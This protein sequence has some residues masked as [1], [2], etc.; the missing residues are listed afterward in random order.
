MLHRFAC[1]VG[2]VALSAM[3]VLCADAS[4]PNLL[5]DGGFESVSG[6][7]WRYWSV[8]GSWPGKLSVTSA[9][10]V[11][12]GGRRCASLAATDLQGKWFGRVYQGS[13]PDLRL[14][15]RYRLA[16][17]AKGK[18]ELVVGGIE[19]RVDAQGKKSY[20]YQ[21]AATPARLTSD[22]QRVVFDY[23]PREPTITA[24]RFYAEV[25]GQDSAAS[26]DD[27]FLGLSPKPGY[28]FAVTADHTMMPVAGSLCIKLRATGP[29]GPAGG[30]VS[31]VLA[32]PSRQVRRDSVAL[33]AKGE[34]SWA[35]A[36]P[37]PGIVSASF[38]HS[39]SG[40]P[41]R[42]Y[43]DVVDKA[44]YDAFASV[45]RGVRVR[46]P[47]HIMF[48]GDSLT[49]LFR[50][51]NYV[52]KVRGWLHHR[53]GDAV[54]VTNAGVGGDYTTRVL[55]RLDSD[56]LAHKPSHVFIFLGHNDS[57]L[58]S[59][60]M[61]KDAVVPPEQFDTEYRQIVGRIQKEIGAKVTIMSAT[62]SV[63]EIT[64]ASADTR[65][66][67]GMAHNLFGQP[68]ALEQFNAIAKK[69]AQDLEANYL[70]VYEPTRTHPDKPSLFTKDGVHV[71]N[72]GNQLLALQVLKYLEAP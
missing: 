20:I 43:V 29:Q 71:S 26:L 55:K 14:G 37:E 66:A 68:A 2:I 72:L 18:G 69:V 17:W 65:Q 64:K 47:A 3:P 31:V 46:T 38:V 24:V 30:T 59:T 44:T 36:A 27:A 28:T 60:S 21:C 54:K 34:A 57:K 49:A 52:D 41:E 61:Y 58:K 51:Y 40:L 13:A 15:A 35:L 53:Y 19:Y 63:Y 12:H 62:S 50:G 8:A 22:W 5:R 42:V 67:A 23:V 11:A 4:R 33:N 6:G 1:C 25:R 56:V 39:E 16:I 9:R 32:G 48:V 7:K 10:G 45:A 70:D